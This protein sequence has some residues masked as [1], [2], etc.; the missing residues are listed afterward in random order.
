MC[1]AGG[2]EVVGRE[3]P[4]AGVDI[5]KHLRGGTEQHAILQRLEG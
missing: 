5:Q 4:W 2:R 1:A 3:T